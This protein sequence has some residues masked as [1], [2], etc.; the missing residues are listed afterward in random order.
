MFYAPMSG[1]SNSKIFFL[2][3]LNSPYVSMPEWVNFER[4]RLIEMECL[5]M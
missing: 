2:P 5:L 1:Q 4:T 3:F